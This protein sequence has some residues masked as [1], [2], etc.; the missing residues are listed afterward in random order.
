MS[1][2]TTHSTSRHST[3]PPGRAS[4]HGA[5]ARRR[6]GTAGRAASVEALVRVAARGVRALR[7]TEALLWGLAAALVTAAAA[8]DAGGVPAGDLAASDLRELF[9]V[10]GAVGLVAA[11]AVLVATWPSD[12]A[13]VRDLDRR[14][15][16]RF[17]LVAA[18]ERER[19][20]RPPTE[21]DHLL[22]ER[23]RADLTASDAFAGHA[24]SAVPAAVAP[25]VAAALL[26]LAIGPLDRPGTDVVDLTAD[27]AG[28]L[29]AAVGQA[30]DELSAQDRI[31][32]SAL[33][34]DLERASRRMGLENSAAAAERLDRVR[35]ELTARAA[36]LDS[37]GRTARAIER[38]L[39]TLATAERRARAATERTGAARS[40]GA[41]STGA[42]S[43]G[44]ERTAQPAATPTQP[45]TS[46]TSPVGA[47]GAP[48]A[49]PSDA[50]D[51][52]APGAA[53][54][55]PGGAEASDASSGPRRDWL[56]P[57]E[58]ALVEAWVESQRRAALGA[59]AN[60]NEERR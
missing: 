16:R 8:L 58:R 53:G 59:P 56:A 49:D 37:A 10:A 26:G 11:S 12:A 35:R 32:L 14:H 20:G 47:D 46:A 1:A 45:G 25:L 28:E 57:Q 52:A 21:L 4:V 2:R 41:N 50:T 18:F 5:S 23:A 48:P 29:G 17:A 60:A 40:G 19:D 30:S 3:H 36:T 38:A 54:T 44:D 34:R 13:I 6:T 55:L 43:A 22:S 33:V 42:S 24:A 31:A 51:S 27:V 39:A 9:A 7:W 15:Q